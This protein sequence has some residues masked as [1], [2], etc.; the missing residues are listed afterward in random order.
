MSVDLVDHPLS[1]VSREGRRRGWG[2]EQDLLWEILDSQEVIVREADSGDQREA[3]GVSVFNPDP[4]GML[5]TR[6]KWEHNSNWLLCWP[7]SLGFVSREEER[8]GGNG[9]KK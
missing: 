7:A 1:V 2:G 4:G 6:S 8:E 5:Y 9:S 3:A